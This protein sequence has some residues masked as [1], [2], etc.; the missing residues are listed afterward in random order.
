MKAVVFDL[1]GVILRNKRL[2]KGV[3][4]KCT[5]FV[6]MYSKYPMDIYAANQKNAKLYMTYGHSLKGILAENNIIDEDHIARVV[7]DF[8]DV[9]YNYETLN[10]LHEFLYSHEFE[11]TT[12]IFGD[13]CD[14]CSKRNVPIHILSN[15]PFEWCDPVVDRL[16]RLYGTRCTIDTIYSSSHSLLSTNT[17]LFKPDMEVYDRVASD[18][19]LHVPAQQV[20]T[21]APTQVPS[22]CFIDDSLINVRPLKNNNIWLPIMYNEEMRKSNKDIVSVT[23][24]QDLKRVVTSFL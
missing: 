8:N 11:D 3:G 23:S 22:L 5:R 13:I 4:N 15:S 14:T 21:Q 1:D 10:D 6:Q 9:V 19:L 20:P 24:M 16:E 7:K 17:Q 2:L 12:R 18:I